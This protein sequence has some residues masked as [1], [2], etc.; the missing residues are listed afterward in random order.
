VRPRCAPGRLNGAA[1][2]RLGATAAP[3]RQNRADRILRPPAPAQVPSCQ[4]DPAAARSA[5]DRKGTFVAK[6]AFSRQKGV[7][8]QKYASVR[9]RGESLAAGRRGRPPH[10]LEVRRLQ[11]HDGRKSH[12]PADKSPGRNRPHRKAVN[13]PRA[14]AQVD[15]KVAV[16]GE[17]K[18]LRRPDARL[19]YE[20][21]S[22]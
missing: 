15:R 2:L 19:P 9:R 3:Q 17:S 20:L 21:T 22:T 4:Q 12:S 10:R 7:S 8:R 11:P 18:A 13:E 14:V 6:N 1:A 16:V 5:S